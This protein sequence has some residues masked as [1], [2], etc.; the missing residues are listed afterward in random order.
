M[1]K[2]QLNKFNKSKPL[3]KGMFKIKAMIIQFK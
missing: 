1:I 2:A 3:C